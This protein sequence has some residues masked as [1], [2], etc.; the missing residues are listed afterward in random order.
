MT[1]GLESEVAGTCFSLSASKGTLVVP[2][3]LLAVPSQPASQGEWGLATAIVH[4]STI[5][6]LEK[7]WPYW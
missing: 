1:T 2:L 5:F 6:F 7:T 3:Y 4:I